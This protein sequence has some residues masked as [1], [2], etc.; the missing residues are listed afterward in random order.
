MPDT[1]LVCWLWHLHWY[2]YQWNTTTN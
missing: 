2:W 1:S